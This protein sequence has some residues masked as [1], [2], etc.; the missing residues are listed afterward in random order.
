MHWKGSAFAQAGEADK[1]THLSVGSGSWE[2]LPVA[3]CAKRECDRYV[4]RV[5][6]YARLHIRVVMFCN[7]L[8]F[9][10]GFR[11]RNG[12]W[13]MMPRARDTKRSESSTGRIKF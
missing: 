7:I 5:K 6:R 3:G 2:T 12:G 8:T 1:C 11:A 4:F 10:T 13:K 9:S